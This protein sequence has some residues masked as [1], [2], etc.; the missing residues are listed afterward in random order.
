MALAFDDITSLSV[1]PI[2]FGGCVAV[3]SFIGVLG[4]I[5]TML[6]GNAVAGWASTVCIACFMGGIQLLCLGVIGEYI[7]KAYMK[8]KVRP[9]YIISEHTSEIEALENA[10]AKITDEA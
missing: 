5:I 9:R 4:A 1:E 3:L 6:L 10:G 8:T 7:G 2:C